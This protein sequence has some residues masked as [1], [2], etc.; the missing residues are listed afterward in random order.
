MN[1]MKKRAKTSIGMFRNTKT[2]FRTVVVVVFDCIRR[3]RL[4]NSR[5]LLLVSLINRSTVKGGDE[6]ETSLRDIFLFLIF[7]YC[8]DR[9]ASAIK[10]VT[11][12]L[13]CQRRE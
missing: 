10:D 8:N 2:N 5:L 1:K 11:K 13:T 3:A 6:G 9:I 12:E 4:D 7:F